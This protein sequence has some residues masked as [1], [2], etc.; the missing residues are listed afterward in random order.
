MYKERATTLNEIINDII[1]L[2]SAPKDLD[3]ELINKWLTSQTKTLLE[4]FLKRTAVEEFHHQ[5]L[6]AIAK[7]VCTEFEVKLVALAQ[8]LRL[9]LTGK[10]RSPGV[11][12]LLEVV[13][14]EESRKRIE[15]LISLL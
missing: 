14:R 8:P 9:A 3:L 6:I 15:K 13:P 5:D 12:E 4:E 7:N 10:T 1:A 11:F 2:D